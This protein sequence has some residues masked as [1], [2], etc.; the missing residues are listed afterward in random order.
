VIHITEHKPGLKMTGFIS[1]NTSVLKNP[2]CSIN[3]CDKKKICSVC[4]GKYMIDRYPRL[5]AKLDSNYQILSKDL[6]IPEINEISGIIKNQNKRFIRIHSIGEISGIEMLSNY[7]EIIEKNPDSIFALWTKRPE[8]IK[9]IHYKPDNL[10]VVYSNPLI[11]K[12]SNKIPVYCDS[13]FNVITYGY[14]MFKGIIPNCS[15]KCIDCLKCYKTD[16]NVIIEL[17]K[18]DQTRIKKGSIKSIEEGIL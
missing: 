14:A 9:Q 16:N 6:T 3:R 15:G 11:D 8:I 10:K 12:P 17:I 2:F 18:A 7:Y 5:K 1:I 13:I 4:Y